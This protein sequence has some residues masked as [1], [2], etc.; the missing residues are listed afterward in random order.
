MARSPEFQS[1]F[2]MLMRCYTKSHPTNS[3][4][5]NDIKVCSYWVLGSLMTSGFEQFLQDMGPR[6]EGMTL[7][8]IDPR[9]HYTAENCRWADSYTQNKNR[10][11]RV[12]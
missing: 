7:D 10:K 8:R 1:W 9:G 5:Y 4:H 12:K 6:P 3:L 11:Q 2:N